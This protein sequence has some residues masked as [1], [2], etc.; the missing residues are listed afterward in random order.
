MV[1]V[2]ILLFAEARSWRKQNG[3]KHY[4]TDYPTALLGKVFYMEFLRNL[5]QVKS[6][7]INNE[8][9]YQYFLFF[10]SPT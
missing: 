4:S 1:V 5:S 7:K 6:L 2:I 3:G 9:T 8:K 10:I